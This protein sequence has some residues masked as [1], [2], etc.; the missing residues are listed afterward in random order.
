MI[1]IL[2]SQIGQRLDG[3]AR[4]DTRP[5]DSNQRHTHTLCSDNITNRLLML[6]KYASL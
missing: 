5:M 6:G 4:T 1:T 3:W 2:N